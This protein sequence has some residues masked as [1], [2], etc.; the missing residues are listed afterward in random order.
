MSGTR[1]FLK[2]SQ[3]TIIKI[4]MII[5]MLS[6]GTSP[7]LWTTP[8][9]YFEALNRRNSTSNSSSLRPTNNSITVSS[10]KPSNTFKKLISSVP[11]LVS[12]NNTQIVGGNRILTYADT[13]LGIVTQF[14]SNWSY[15]SQ[16]SAVCLPLLKRKGRQIDT[17]TT[18]N[19][20]CGVA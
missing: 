9:Q 7:V 4:I 3:A 18:P 6:V 1:S 2:N 13:Y 17:K 16:A 12:T 11:S 10:D 19:Q 5:I 14:P 15:K 20:P 8:P